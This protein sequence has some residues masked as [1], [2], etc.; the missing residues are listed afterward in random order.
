MT[1]KLPRDGRELADWTYTATTTYP[2][3]E[4]QMNYG[5]AWHTADIVAGNLISVWVYG[6]D[7]LAANPDEPTTPGVLVSKDCTPRLRVK[8]NPAVTI[9]AQGGIKLIPAS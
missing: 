5:E 4:I 1:M 6:P 8:G 2:S 7:F 9:R 3:W